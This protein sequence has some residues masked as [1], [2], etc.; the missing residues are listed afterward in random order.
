MAQK[1]DLH[2]HSN[3][4]IDGELLPEDLVRGS[5][6]A[7]LK[8]IALTDHNSTRGVLQAQ[9]AARN[10]G[11]Q[12]ISGIEISSMLHG[13][14]VHILGY[15]IDETD[16]VFAELETSV[17]KQE[18]LASG[19][20]IELI[21]KCCGLQLDGAWLC[22]NANQGVITGELIAEAA[23]NDAENASNP[24]MQAYQ[25]GGA[26]SD[27]PYLNFYW[28]YCAPGKPAYVPIRY[29]EAAD[30][31]A[32]IHACG[33]I[34]VAA[35]PG[36]GDGCD[37]QEVEQLTQWGLEGIEAYSSYHTAKQTGYYCDLAEAYGLM[38]T[39]GSDFHG[40][41]KP[42]IRLGDVYCEHAEALAEILLERLHR[43]TY[44]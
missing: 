36:A 4:S 38:I 44:P 23:L 6:E 35:H 16:R 8:M 32:L 12:L 15:G 3:V 39:C 31:I 1:V 22:K 25:P 29:M 20:R 2:M 5:V 40:K 26:R 28:D 33:G 9:R 18:R 11:I 42:A 7:G 21:R 10:C 43:R 41:T 17:L 37:E 30:A 24:Q 27:N 13:K 19:L 34:A 14:E